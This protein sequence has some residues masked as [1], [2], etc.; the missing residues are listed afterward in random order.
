MLASQLPAPKAAGEGL[1]WSPS[2]SLGNPQVARRLK[3]KK[4]YHCLAILSFWGR[5]DRISPPVPEDDF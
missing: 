2:P 3:K 1:V 4:K 5:G